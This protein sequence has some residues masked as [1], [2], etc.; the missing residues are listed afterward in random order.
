M[1]FP[2]SLTTTQP[3]ESLLKNKKKREKLTSFAPCLRHFHSSPLRI[4]VPFTHL[5]H[6]STPYRKNT[7]N[8]TTPI[9]VDPSR[10]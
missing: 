2:L 4:P 3:R 10:R 1:H 6:P 5:L 8:T 7:H 9:D